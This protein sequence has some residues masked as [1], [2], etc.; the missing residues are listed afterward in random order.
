MTIIPL[1]GSPGKLKKTS[2]SK[3]Q[4]KNIRFNTLKPQNSETPQLIL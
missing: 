3:L 4:E 2:G 1:V